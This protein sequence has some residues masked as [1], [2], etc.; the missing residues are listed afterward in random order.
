MVR[1]LGLQGGVAMEVTGRCVE[2]FR[3]RSDA[4]CVLARLARGRQPNRN[5]RLR[6]RGRCR[7]RCS[8]LPSL[9]LVCQAPSLICAALPSRL[10]LS[11]LRSPRNRKVEGSNPTSGSK[12]PA[13]WLKWIALLASRRKAWPM[14]LSTEGIAGEVPDGHPAAARPKTAA[15]SLLGRSSSNAAWRL[16]ALLPLESVSA[17]AMYAFASAQ[18]PGPAAQA[19]GKPRRGFALAALPPTRN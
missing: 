7:G 1:Q 8:A 13:Q 9:A 2:T 18:R 12:L 15:P 14:I 6:C 19:E 3:L 5:D 16:D 10:R 17:V 4:L 11:G